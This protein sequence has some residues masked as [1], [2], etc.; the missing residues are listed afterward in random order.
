VAAGKSN[1]RIMRQDLADVR[2]SDASLKAW[3]KE[4][5]Q[6]ARENEQQEAAMAKA[7]MSPAR[8]RR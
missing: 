5:H 7:M 8:R 3:L 2:R 4:Q 6:M 1:I